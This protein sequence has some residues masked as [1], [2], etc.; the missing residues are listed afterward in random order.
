VL[1][2][3]T[4]LGHDVSVGNLYE[5]SD[6]SIW[7][8]RFA[9]LLEDFVKMSANVSKFRS[10]AKVKTKIQQLRAS[11]RTRDPSI[12]AQCGKTLDREQRHR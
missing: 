4:G 11:D 5:G 2:E 12:G 3:F 9:G 1:L 10:D 8:K 6:P 7:S